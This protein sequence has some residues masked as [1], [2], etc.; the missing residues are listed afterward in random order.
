MDSSIAF[1]ALGEGYLPGP[2]PAADL[3]DKHREVACQLNRHLKLGAWDAI[4]PSI[5]F[6][7][8]I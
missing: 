8:E 2:A 7:Y 3:L 1:L 4:M 6:L 5:Q